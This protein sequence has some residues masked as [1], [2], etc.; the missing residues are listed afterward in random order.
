MAVKWLGK[1]RCRYCDA[2]ARVGRERDGL[3]QTFRVICRCGAN[4]QVGIHTPA[5]E[6]VAGALERWLA[7][8]HKT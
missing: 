3:G 1:V 6:Q 7:W 4:V 8:H 5:G 2:E